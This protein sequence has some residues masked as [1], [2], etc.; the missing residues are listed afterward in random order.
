M[1]N[2]S[3]SRMGGSFEGGNLKAGAVLLE[4]TSQNHTFAKLQQFYEGNYSFMQ[5]HPLS[6]A[7]SLNLHLSALRTRF[8][9]PGFF[10]LQ[11]TGDNGHAE[12][13]LVSKHKKAFLK[14]N[15]A[16]QCSS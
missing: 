7:S 5:L 2:S 15:V 12:T 3:V 13:C 8:G 14:S 16:L 6:K 1:S 11:P 9:C 4:V 10:R